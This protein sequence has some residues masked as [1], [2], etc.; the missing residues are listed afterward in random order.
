MHDTQA[1]E[2]KHR[3]NIKKAMNRVK[4]D[5]TSTTS[6]SMLRWDFRTRTWGKITARVSQQYNRQVFQRRR[7]DKIT[8]TGTNRLRPADDLQP[9]MTSDNFSPLSAGGDNLMSPDARISY[10]ELAHLIS[11]SMG[12]EL[13]H[14]QDD[15]HVRLFC[16][17]K[18]DQ[19]GSIR[20]CW[21]TE[22]KYPYYNG[23]RR[24]VMEIDLGNNKRGLAQLVSFIEME[25]L[26]PEST[27]LLEKA[28]L[29]RWLSPSVHSTCRDDFGR[30]MCPYPLST[31]H[32]LWQ[33]SD[34]GSNRACFRVRGFRN[35]VHAQGM[36]NHVPEPQR[37]QAIQNEKRAR[38]DVLEYGSIICHTNVTIDP[39]TGHILQTIQ[40][41]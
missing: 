24:D 22:S 27:A 23:A 36:W 40:M 4:K 41:I 8:H 18:I 38:Y 32:C 2:G 21:A 34:A 11:R 35:R 17:A 33:W 7:T 6:Q 14:V 15:L 16:S 29:V 37:T 1:P 39:S 3:V 12:W 13:S 28:I 25:N 9:L 10:N 5:D 30:P 26:P 19:L 31:N 20:M